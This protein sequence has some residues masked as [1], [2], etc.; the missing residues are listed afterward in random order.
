MYIGGMAGTGKSQVHQSHSSNLW[1]ETTVLCVPDHGTYRISCCISVWLYIFILFWNQWLPAN[2]SIKTISGIYER[3]KDVK[4]VF[5]W[6]KY[7][8]RLLNIY[9][10]SSQMS[11]ECMFM[12]NHLGEKHDFCRWL[13]Q[14]PPPGRNPSLYSQ[15]VKTT[16]TQD[17]Q[18]QRSEVGYWKVTLA[19]IHCGSDLEANYEAEDTDS[20]RCQV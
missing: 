14:L 16:L 11:L 4:Y 5:S 20:G 12:I 7:H 1:E 9:T 6:M 10:I 18:P 13:A 2:E 8:V 17:S 19:S 3:L 15:T